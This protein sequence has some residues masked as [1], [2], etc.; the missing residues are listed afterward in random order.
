MDGLPAALITGAASGIGKFIA[1]G[2]AAKGYHLTVSYALQS[3][4]SSTCTI[5]TMLQVSQL[6]NDQCADCHI[7]LL[8][9]W[10]V[11]I[12]TYSS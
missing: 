7:T 5:K 9:I 11:L 6:E 8:A 10:C 3:I 1:L 4:L 2:L 12:A